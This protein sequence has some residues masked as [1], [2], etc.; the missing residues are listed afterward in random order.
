MKTIVRAV[1]AAICAAV[2]VAASAPKSAVPANADDKT[3]LHVLNRIGFGARPG[4]IDRVRQMGLAPY[5]D[6][7]LHPERIADAQLATRLTEYETLNKSSRD[8]AQEYYLPAQKA[9]QRAQAARK[10]SPSPQNASG[11]AS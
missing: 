11:D 8:I 5:I 10:N 6:Q 3:I 9:R 1:V 7:Q 2:T 4:D